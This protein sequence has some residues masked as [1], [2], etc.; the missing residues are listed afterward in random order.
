M[1]GIDYQTLS[2]P[3]YNTNTPTQLTTVKE[4]NMESKNK[5]SDKN[6]SYTSVKTGKWV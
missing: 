1:P 4:E 5:K 2:N 6:T 3:Y